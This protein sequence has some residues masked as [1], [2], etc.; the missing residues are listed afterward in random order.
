MGKTVF[1][2]SSEERMGLHPGLKACVELFN[3]HR[4]E[5]LIAGAH[6]LALHARPLHAAR[7]LTGPAR[8]YPKLVISPGT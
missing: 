1:T 3:A 6:A 8:F 7:T 5:D 2:W 4:V